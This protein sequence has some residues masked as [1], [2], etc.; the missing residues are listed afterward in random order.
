MTPTI[1]I[2]PVRKS[3]VVNATQAR[4]FAVFT[5]GMARWWPATHT[6]MKVPP[7]DHIVEPRVGGRWYQI[8]EDG[9]ECDNGRVLAWEPP[10]RVLLAW[11]INADWQYDPDLLT[12]V[13]VNFIAEGANRT[14]VELE[15]RHL[16]RMGAKAETARAAVDA[17][18]GWGA[19]LES[20]K[21]VA[22]G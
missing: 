3:L 16:E 2:A 7:K 14:R 21:R 15:H 18:G 10:Q 1:K 20:F 22:E 9:S 13:E 6:I 17:P 8:G 4:A 11:Q 12:E 19:L 5:A